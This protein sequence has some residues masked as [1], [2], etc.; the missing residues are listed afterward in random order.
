M[1]ISLT[2]QHML[3]YIKHCY[4]VLFVTLL[5]LL[6]LNGNSVVVGQFHVLSSPRDLTVTVGDSADLT[7]IVGETSTVLQQD[8]S[9]VSADMDWIIA[10]DSTATVQRVNADKSG[11]IDGL[12]YGITADRGEYSIE[13]RAD[14]LTSADSADC[15]HVIHT[16]VL[17]I[18]NATLRDAGTFA[19]GDERQKGT[20]TIVEVTDDLD[21]CSVAIIIVGL[22]A[23]VGWCLS[24]VE[25]GVVM[26][27]CL[28]KPQHA[29]RRRKLVRRVSILLP[30]SKRAA[31]EFR[32]G[33]KSEERRR[34]ARSARGEEDMVQQV[35]RLFDRSIN[36]E[37]YTVDRRRRTLLTSPE[38]KADDLIYVNLADRR[39]DQRGFA[40]KSQPKKKNNKVQFKSGT[41]PGKNKKNKPSN[42]K[43][44]PTGTGRRAGE[45]PQVKKKRPESLAVVK[46]FGVTA[47]TKAGETH[48]DLYM[49]YP[50][51]TRNAKKGD[52]YAESL[53]S[54]EFVSTPL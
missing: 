40:Q 33:K 19:C 25:F 53:D 32:E 4:N 54:S 39:K 5:I 28:Q 51:L 36:P 2:D 13:Y 3:R 8:V 49:N 45:K 10:W 14:M 30:Q 38:D 43:G 42:R 6:P 34:R 48:L 1:M 20:L 35:P 24:I 9:A 11:A 41:V 16:S 12:H 23:V 52:Q 26:H 37:L 44:G 29:A 17:T 15:T 50:S 21:G 18:K 22:I 47:D 27:M 31:Y 46:P 7:C